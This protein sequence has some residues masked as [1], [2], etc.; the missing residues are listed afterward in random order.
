[1]PIFNKL[2]RDKIPQIIE[3]KWETAQIHIADD[4]EYWKSLKEKL[5]EEVNEFLSDE[6]K[7]EMADVMEVIK[8]IL[9]YK[10]YTTEEIEA[11]RQDKENKRWWFSQR[12]ILESTS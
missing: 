10:W 11:I 6:S 8:A 7:E 9:A 3:S 5:I 1:M 4:S 2:V 12:I